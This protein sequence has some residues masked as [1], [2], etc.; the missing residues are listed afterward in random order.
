VRHLE[1]LPLQIPYPQQVQQVAKLLARPP[2]DHGAKFVLDET[3]CG[4]P[5][6]DQFDRAGLRPSRITI[7]AGTEVTMH[8]GNSYHVP[9]AFLISGLE[10]RLHS[11]E[12]RIAAE[13]LEAPV[14]REELKDFARKVSDAGRVTY[15]ARSGKHDDLILAICIALFLA[16][17]RPI[18][19]VEPLNID[20]L[21][22]RP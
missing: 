12:L 8:G 18:C 16:C 1:R 10:S 7:T 2:L 13:L 4:R 20:A 3:G 9:K 19:R 17:N 21:A 6:A 15:N 14:L 11:G 22:F 5:V